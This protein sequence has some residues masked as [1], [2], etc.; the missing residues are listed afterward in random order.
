MKMGGIIYARVRLSYIC[1]IPITECSRRECSFVCLCVFLRSVCNPMSEIVIQLCQVLCV[2]VDV[3]ECS[4]SSSGVFLMFFFIFFI[5]ASS[6][7]AILLL[8]CI[9]LIDQ[10]LRISKSWS[11]SCILLVLLFVL[12]LLLIIIIITLWLLIR[13]LAVS[14]INPKASMAY[15]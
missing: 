15:Y 7:S 10:N 13:W 14:I 11:T 3:H 2:R 9:L 12:V 4:S 1:L 5:F 8:F 6:C